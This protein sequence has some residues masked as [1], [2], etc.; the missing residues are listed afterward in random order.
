MA[1][2][3]KVDVRIWGDEKVLRLSAPAPSGR[4]LFLYLL[5]NPNTSNIP[6]LYRAG[7]AQLAEELGWKTEAFREAFREVFREG[8]AEADW[9]ARLVWLPN[10]IRYN[11]PESANVVKSWATT[12]EELP[13]C[14]LKQKAREKLAFH[15]EGMGK[16]FAEAFAKA[17]PKGMGESGTGTGTGTGNTPQPPADAGGAVVETPKPARR[18]RKQASPAGPESIPIPDALNHDPFPATWA[19]W[20]AERRERRKPLTARAAKGQ[21][22]GLEPLGPVKAAECVSA[23][24]RNGW[25]GLFPESADVKAKPPPTR[26]PT[27][28]EIQMAEFAADQAVVEQ[29]RKTIAERNGKPHDQH[30]AAL[31]HFLAE[32]FGSG[33]G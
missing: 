22:L 9:K 32:P 8:L 28:Q 10:A 13:E 12:W 17:L 21:L 19:E 4:F 20:I 16:G 24:I 33:T 18:E 6:G 14:H 31:N 23:S 30:L 27:K 7:E 1:R 15:V 2:Y 29:A 5:T 26:F 11:A 25:A 3:R